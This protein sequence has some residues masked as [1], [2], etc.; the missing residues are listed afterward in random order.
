MAT[1]SSTSELIQISDTA[2]VDKYMGK[3]KHPLKDVAQELRQL[4]LSADK[5]VGRKTEDHRHRA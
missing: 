1:L 4:I 5:S 3:L 2:A